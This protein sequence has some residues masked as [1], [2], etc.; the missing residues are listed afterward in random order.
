MIKIRAK[1]GPH[2]VVVDGY[3]SDTLDIIFTIARDALVK[4][5]RL[6]L[7]GNEGITLEVLG[8]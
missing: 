7:L 5:Y 1:H 2:I 4:A 6:N 8:H 3:E